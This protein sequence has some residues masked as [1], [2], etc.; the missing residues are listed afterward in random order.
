MH[1]R[2][3]RVR[4][5]ELGWFDELGAR[6]IWG[7]EVVC[8]DEVYEE[9]EGGE[10]EKEE[11]EWGD[12]CRDCWDKRCRESKGG[13]C[14]WFVSICMI[15][16]RGLLPQKRREERRSVCSLICM[17]GGCQGNGLLYPSVR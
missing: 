2:L 4:W 10:V 9:W 12:D 17:F 13:S 6:R 3:L 8:V 16:V 11:D 14:R 7:W 1:S 15:P 5:R